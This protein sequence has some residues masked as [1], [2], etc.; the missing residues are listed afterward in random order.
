GNS[1]SLTCRKDLPE[2]IRRNHFQLIVPTIPRLFIEPPSSKLRRMPEPAPL[3]MVILDLRHQLRSQRLPRQVLSLAP[4]APTTRHALR[5]APLPPRMLE[6]SV[7]PIWR[8][9]FGKL[10]TPLQTE[11]GTHADM[12]QLAPIVEQPE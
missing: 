6:E 10:R 4:T 7:L 12:L 5:V 11:A 9:I 2:F 1:P 8:E 3:H